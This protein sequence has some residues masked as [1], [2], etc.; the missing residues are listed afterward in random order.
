MNV[1]SAQHAQAAFFGVLSFF[2][3]LLTDF[4]FQFC[5]LFFYTICFAYIFI[6]DLFII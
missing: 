6:F 3:I 2:H 1:L 4:D 5:P